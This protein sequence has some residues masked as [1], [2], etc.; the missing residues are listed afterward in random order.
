MLVP[1]D[2]GVVSAAYT[3]QVR[4]ERGPSLAGVQASVRTRAGALGSATFVFTPG[5]GG[6]VLQAVEEGEV[7]PAPAP[8]SPVPTTPSDAATDDP[9]EETTP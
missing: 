5:D 7:T 9:G 4:H 1:D 3:V 8:A 6:V 2:S